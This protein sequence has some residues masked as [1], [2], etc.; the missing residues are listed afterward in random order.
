MWQFGDPMGTLPDFTVKTP[1]A[2]ARKGD[3]QGKGSV[4]QLN[5]DWQLDMIERKNNRNLSHIALC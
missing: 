1:K 3:W 2:K 4:V 5:H